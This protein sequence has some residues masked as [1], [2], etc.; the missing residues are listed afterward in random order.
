V[1]GKQCLPSDIEWDL[2]RDQY[3]KKTVGDMNR[4]CPSVNIP[5]A[6]ENPEI[7]PLANIPG[8]IPMRELMDKETNL[9]KVVREAGKGLMD[10]LLCK[11]VRS[12][13]PSHHIPVHYKDIACLP[14]QQQ[15]GWKNACQDELKALQKRHV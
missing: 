7:I 15:I 9:K 13:G 11:A 12:S 4:G 2:I 10:F 8:E 1:Y 3:W 14:Q 6:P 5:W